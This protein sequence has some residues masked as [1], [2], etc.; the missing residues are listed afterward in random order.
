MNVQLIVN[1]SDRCGEAPIW[2]TAQRRLIWA[3]ITAGLMYEHQP[4]SGETKTFARDIAVSGIAL[5]SDGRLVIAGSRG[6][7]LWRRSGDEQTVVSTHDG[8]TLNFND[9]LADPQGRIYAGT[10]YWGANGMERPGKLYLIETNGT[11]RVVDEGIELSNGLGLSP[12]NRTLYFSDTIARK[13]YAYDVDSTSGVLKNKR[14]FVHVPRD[15]GIPDGLTVD[16]EGFVWNAQW[17]GSQV[18]RYDP[19]GKVERRIAIPAKQTSS[20]AFGGDD[21]TDLY[22]TTAAE[23]WPSEHMPPGYDPHSGAVG[24]PLYRI[25]LGPIRGRPENRAALLPRT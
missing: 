20:I 24:G 18:V 4:A 23:G 5:N 17:Y 22:I 8:E 1:N 12:D 16:A 11:A 15:E 9:I 3:D 13:I 14:V 19:E 10:Y 7:L 21:L 25:R 6:I 2:D